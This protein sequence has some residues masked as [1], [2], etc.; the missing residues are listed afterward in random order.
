MAEG[1]FLTKKILLV[2]E[3]ATGAIPANP[4]CLEFL[5]ESF[6]YKETQA[7]EEII[8]LGSGGDASPM[9]FGTSSYG[10]S[11]GLV[12]SVDNLPI[13][14][15]HIAGENLSVANATADA[16]PVVV[17]AVAV[18]DKFNHSDGKH[19]LTCTV[20]G[21]TTGTE[22]TLE[23]N[24]NDD[25]N[26]KVIDGTATFIAMQLLKTYSFERKQQIP[27]F[28]VEYELE[29]AAGATFYKRFSNVY[30]NT[31]P[32]GMTGGTISLKVS[33]DFVGATA[34][35]SED[36]DW[37]ENLSAK[38]GAVIIPQFKDFYSYEDCTVKADT[39]ALC[40]VESINL[41]VSRNVTVEDARSLTLS[42]TD[43]NVTFDTAGAV[44]LNTTVDRLDVDANGA[45]VI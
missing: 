37:D 33:G 7:S 6:D 28:T 42:A 3:D 32:M 21:D 2:K 10:G 34:I 39:V 12:A 23:V 40:K 27:S 9:S 17:T 1:G 13:I 22:P 18:G 11:I 8:L 38:A 15:T 26:T 45:I 31:M 36:A 25:R 16:Y 29:D 41:D 43:A 44:E 14:L 19:T 5:S 4:Q 20:A 24:P 30:M 35:D